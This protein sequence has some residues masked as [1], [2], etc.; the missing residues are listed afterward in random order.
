MSL[1]KNYFQQTD[2]PKQQAAIPH[3]WQPCC[4]W[5]PVVVGSLTQSTKLCRTVATPALALDPF[6]LVSE[7]GNVLFGY[8]L[9]TADK[10]IS[11]GRLPL[12]LT[13]M[14]RLFFLSP[15]QTLQSLYVLYFEL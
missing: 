13:N 4:S 7:K 9:L 15:E 11:R 12:P 2:M 3:L 10:L 6:L 8:S 1:K 5:C 14:L